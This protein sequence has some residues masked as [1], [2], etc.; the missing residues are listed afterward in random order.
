MKTFVLPVAA[1][2]VCFFMFT[3]CSPDKT[4]NPSGMTAIAGKKT[5]TAAPYFLKASRNAG[6][7]Y[8]SGAT[9]DTSTITFTINNFTGSTGTVAI[10]GH[11]VTATYD[12]LA[13]SAGL[14]I[15]RAAYGAIV[16]TSVSPNL[17]GTFYFTCSD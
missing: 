3:G 7:L 8:I 9:S 1:L 15:E 2:I 4:I 11:F 13:D 17:V 16:F 10:D 14:S 6:D 5:F 12:S